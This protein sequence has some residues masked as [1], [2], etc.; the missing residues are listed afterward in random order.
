MTPT[1]ENKNS[2]LTTIK[3]KIA[4]I[5]SESDRELESSDAEAENES[6]TDLVG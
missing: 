4:Y 5:D 2:K 6:I 3:R 1:S